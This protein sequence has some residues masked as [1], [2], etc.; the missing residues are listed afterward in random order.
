VGPHRGWQG[1][2]ADDDRVEELDRDVPGV[3][4]GATLADRQQPA[5][6]IER[7]GQV[8]RRGDQRCGRLSHW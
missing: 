5:A 7:V 4:Q 1:A 8:A 3:G 2:L 6:A